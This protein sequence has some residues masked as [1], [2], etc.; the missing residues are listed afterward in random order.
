MRFVQSSAIMRAYI[1]IM[2]KSV[3][4][5]GE[6]K[7]CHVAQWIRCWNSNRCPTPDPG[8]NPHVA[9]VFF[10]SIY[11]EK[12]NDMYKTHVKYDT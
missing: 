1:Y 8:S 2:T 10:L 12:I 5:V 9:R 7:R 3:N 6:Q 11:E 4:H